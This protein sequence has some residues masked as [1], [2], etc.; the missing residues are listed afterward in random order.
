M[1]VILI[2]GG[3][4]LTGTHMVNYLLIHTDADVIIAGRNLEKADL[5]AGS[6]GNKRLS[7]RRA[8][9]A[10][11]GSLRAAL[12]GVD[13]CLVASP[14]THQAGLVARA[15]LDSRVDY[16]D[17]QFSK[18]KLA[19][20]YSLEHQIQEAGLC[21]VTEAGF[22]PGLPAA[23]VRYAAS[24]LDQIDRAVTAGYLNIGSGIP[25][26]EAVD[27]L[28]E[29][30]IDYE[31]Q[32]FKN[33]KWTSP[34]SWDMLRFDFGDGIGI[35]TCYSMFFEELRC[36]PQMYPS[37]KNTGF[38]ISGS[39]WL[40]DLVITPIV[41]LGLKL[42][43]QRALRPMGRLMWWGMQRSRPPYR[44]MVAVQ[45]DGVKNGKALRFKAGISHQDGYVLTAIPVVAFLK[46][47]LD[48]TAR[49]QGLHLM[50]QVAEPLR[51]FEDMQAMG[52][53]LTYA[54]E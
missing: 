30:F 25:F 54:E 51:L 52:A 37:L 31:A 43:P 44:V 39:N 33:G 16:L 8:D 35:R 53:A 46:Q 28:M 40:A 41:M 1:A 48:G 45:A 20:L 50:G 15:C 9:A 36:L 5:L 32:V 26:T 11:P 17:I 3:Y 18:K 23:L 24:H 22:H 42:A 29:G 27:E 49:R 34:K 38:Y 14:T 10:D 13:L 12:E 47:Y 7:T 4:G 19:A 21:F 6:I 2:L